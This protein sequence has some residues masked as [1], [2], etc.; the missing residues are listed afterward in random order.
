VPPK[1]PATNTLAPSAPTSRLASPKDGAHT[2]A[3]QLVSLTR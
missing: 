1:K 3:P 2:T